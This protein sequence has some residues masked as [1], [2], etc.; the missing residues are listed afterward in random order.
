MNEMSEPTPRPPKRPKPE[1]KPAGVGIIVGVIVA[2]GIAIVLVVATTGGSSALTLGKVAAAP[3]KYENRKLRVVGMIKHGSTSSVSE[4]GKAE[5]RFALVD[6]EGHEVPIVYRQTLPDPY[7]EGRTAIVEGTFTQA[8]GLDASKLTVKCPSK[9]QTEDGSPVD[10]DAY[11][12]RYDSDS[13]GP[14]S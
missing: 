13:P 5:T 9:Y 8:G 7:K 6:D 2:V 12:K 1:Q 11:K 4:G 3:E 10:Y 14:R